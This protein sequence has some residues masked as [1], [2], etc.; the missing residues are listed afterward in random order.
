MNL[1]VDDNTSDA[2]VNRTVVHEFGHV[3]GCIHEHQSPL[4]SIKWNKD[5]VYRECKEN[6]GWDKETTEKNILNPTNAKGTMNSSFDS[7][8][9]MIYPI[10]SNWTYD[11]ISDP[12]SMV[13][14]KLDKIFAAKVYPFRTH[15][16][17]RLSIADM[18][19]WYPPRA[20]NSRLIQFDPVYDETPRLALGLTQ[21]DEANSSNIRVRLQAQPIGKADFMLNLDSYD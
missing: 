14:S 13:L 19:E 11:R 21:L 4:A 16:E 3:I 5:L 10:P 6:M 8:S 1:G 7:N 9:I 17:G 2:D 18:R 20:L 15:N 12:K